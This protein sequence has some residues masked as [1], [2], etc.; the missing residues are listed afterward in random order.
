MRRTLVG[1]IVAVV[2]GVGWSQTVAAQS[3]E[4]LRQS[5][6]LLQQQVDRLQAALNNQVGETAIRGWL[7]GSIMQQASFVDGSGTTAWVQGWA[8]K[9]GVSDSAQPRT[10]V[11]VDG[12]LT[13]DVAVQRY[14]R[15]DVIAAYG[16]FCSALG[17][18]AP[19]PGISFLV[20]LH[21]Y[22]SGAHTITLRLLDAE[23]SAT[24]D[25][26]TLKII[27]P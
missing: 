24:V 21:H 5:A 7:D 22:A 20:D 1:M 23:T 12:L 26:N 14:Q 8:F 4:D 25:S 2:I 9:C 15:L 19:H 17:G 3:M 27:I 18:M 11:L 16:E 13:A 10:Q 6:I